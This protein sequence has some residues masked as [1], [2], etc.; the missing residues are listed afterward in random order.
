MQ[1]R[2]YQE[3][4]IEAIN[5]HFATKETNPCVVLPTGAGKSPLMAWTIWSFIDEHPPF[6]CIVLAHVKE[7]IRQNAEKMKAIWPLAPVGIYSAGLKSRDKHD[8]I[9]FAGIQS[10]YDK[11]LDFPPFDLIIVDEA[12]RIPMKGDGL[13]RRFIADAKL[14]NPHVRVLG[15]TATPYR[16]DGGEI[17]HKDHILQEII[18][19]A[20]VRDLIEGG[21]LCRLRSKAGDA[22]PDTSGLHIRKGEF[23]EKEVAALVDPLVEQ[24]VTEALTMLVGRKSRIW[25]CAFVGHACA[26]SEALKS[27]GIDAPVI[28]AKTSHAERDETI[29]RFTRGEISDL[30]NVNVLSEG[31]DAQRIDA[32]IMLRPTASPGLYYQQIGRGLRLHPNKADCLVLDF[33]GNIERHGPIDAVEGEKVELRKCPKCKELFSHATDTC[34]GCGWFETVQC[35]VCGVEV[36]KGTVQCPCGYL[37]V[38]K[39][40]KF[41]DCGARNQMHAEICVNCNRP[42]QKI[43]R[44]IKHNAKPSAASILSND[45]PWTV[46]VTEVEIKRHVKA[47]SDRAVLRVV[48]HGK[49]EQHSE[50]VCLEHDGYARTKAENWWKRRFKEP[51]PAS[52]T[53][54][55]NRMF[56]AQELLAMTQ[57]IRVRQRGKYTEVLSVEIRD[58]QRAAVARS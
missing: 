35:E 11:A 4:A 18:Y 33:A 50:W 56:L 42:F 5:N 49:Y 29:R 30:C 47:G 14:N 7:L 54:A 40:C 43:E 9:T 28:H 55:M 51:A 53:D 48:Y 41:E 23:I 22:T 21:F 39:N 13:Y 17:C 19:E 57:T 31:F 8:Q 10:V 45:E 36:R 32:V 6:R 26:V 25:F 20:N 34:P 16:L 37:I 38:G 15:V 2:P 3:E 24:A 27:R 44:E 52:V 46:D 1:P 58:E 12:H